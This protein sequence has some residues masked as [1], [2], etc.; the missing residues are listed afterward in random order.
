MVVENIIDYP[1]LTLELAKDY[2]L[3][4]FE[5][6]KVLYSSDVFSEFLYLIDQGSV[7]IL[8]FDPI[9]KRQVSSAIL[10]KGN[11]VGGESLLDKSFFPYQISAK[12]AG[13][14]IK[15]PLSELNTI[16]IKYPLLKE[17]WLKDISQQQLLIFFKTL[18]QLRTLTTQELEKIVPYFQQQLIT[19]ETYLT[20][21]TSSDIARYWLYS[22][23]IE[24]DK[25][26]VS[27]PNQGDSWSYQNNNIL[28]LKTTTNVLLYY[29][30][31][32]NWQI[33]V[34][35]I[36]ELNNI[37]QEKS[38]SD[39]DQNNTPVNLASE[40]INTPIIITK[41]KESPQKLSLSESKKE[42]SIE[43]D[44]PKPLKKVRWLW[45]NYPFIE[46][47][48]S[49]DCGAAC[50]A[51]ISEYWGKNLNLNFLRNL[52]KVGRSGSSLKNLAK[53][54]ESLGYLASP[55]RADFQS[56]AKEKNP[57]IAHWKGDHY[58]VVYKVKGHNLIVADPAQGKKTISKEEFIYNWSSH[59]LI[60]EPTEKLKEVESA[61]PS[62]SKFIGALTRYQ[63]LGV[64]IIF[65]SI[66]IQLLGLITPLF[67]QIIFDQ[68]VVNKSQITLNVFIIGAILCGF[69]QI[70]LS[71]VRQ[72][73]LSYLSNRLNLTMI[74]AFIKH[75]LSLPLKFFELRRVGDILTR[76]SENQ[77]IQ[78]FL[79]KQ[80]LL[81]WLDFLTGFIYLGLMLYYNWQLTLLILGLIP[82]IILL[83]LLATPFL[84]KISKEIFNTSAEQ[85]SSLVEIL[86]GIATVKSTAVEQDL[87]WR[88]E[89]TLT[90]QLNTQFTGQKFAIKLEFAS[91]LINSIG[92]L[93]ILWFGASL[94]IQDQL[95]IGQL[96]AFNMMKGFVISPAISLVNL[97]DELQQVLISVEKLNDVFDYKPEEI[98]GQP[99]LKLPVLQGNIKL[100][101]VTFRYEEDGEKNTLE[102]ICLDIKHGQ[103]IAIVGRSGSGKSTLI[104]LLEGLYQP[105]RGKILFDGH[106]I[107]HISPH[108][109]RSQLGVVPQEC[110]LF[111]GTIL[112][113]ITLYRPEFSLEE[114]TKVAKLAEA[115]GFIQSMPLGYNTKVGERGA[116]LSGGQR[117]RVAIARALLGEPPVLI[118]D[119]ATSS[120][121]TE[122]ERR[123]QQ[124]LAILARNRTMIIIAHRLSTVK[125][126]D[127]IIVLDQGV[128][129]EQG[130]HQQLIEKKGLYYN[131]AQQQLDI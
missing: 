14:L 117:Q 9:R 7:R 17:I 4:D 37:F 104:K 72:Y 35:L 66:L 123:F 131:L 8:S 83:T 105:I 65:V 82:P 110:F 29:I 113:N 102:N 58:I 130:N 63:S 96:V 69:W 10:N 1:S 122:S 53:G 47:Q 100:E 68:V 43:I 81:A 26:S 114:V 30:T 103:T 115:H 23:Q 60:L 92:S 112:D 18:T 76:V 87:R 25:D 21:Q 61:K 120:L 80:V 5:L 109:L 36:P 51:M 116:N 54:A 78:S 91:G 40:K 118:L 95:T 71:G 27:I 22:G 15:I 32:D 88:W 75:T 77:K 67:T 20:T 99:L 3:I 13:K 124:N 111:S 46:Q 98:P 42:E 101:N 127:L 94:V 41:Q 52:L 107:A 89:E 108:S 34:N 85:S 126:A 119:E 39:I 121:D 45:E 64:Q 6:G 62:L 79:V 129:L 19:S 50:L 59:A 48:S 84:R 28:N 97:W 24:S 106:D 31:K 49:S 2:Q 86:N 33:V 73:L 38:L 74:S 12:T 55:V 93:V 44:F 90:N 11:V 70:S 57:W 56:M 16:F 125:N 128:I